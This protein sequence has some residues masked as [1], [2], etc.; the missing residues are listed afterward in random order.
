MLPC[1][2]S[3]AI[4]FF[5]AVYFKNFVSRALKSLTDTRVGSVMRKL[6]V[7]VIF[8]APLPPPLPS[9]SLVM[10]AKSALLRQLVQ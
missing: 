5:P 3:I 10:A 8:S 1:T 7:A 9:L 4:L 6:L 2:Y